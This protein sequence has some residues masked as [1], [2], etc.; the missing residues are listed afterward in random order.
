MSFTPSQPRIHNVFII[1]CSLPP[2]VN[3]LYMVALISCIGST[4]VGVFYGGNGH[5]LGVQILGAITI[6]LWTLG[7]G[8]TLFM[9]LR[10]LGNLRV[11][12]QEEI[13]GLDAFSRENL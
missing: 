7:A 8:F 6:S 11:S 4:D 10:R 9:T 12:Q 2:D 13:T 5:Q 3:V 1:V